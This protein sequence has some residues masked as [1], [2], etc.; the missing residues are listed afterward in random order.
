MNTMFAH[1]GEVNWVRP[2]TAL[3][4]PE[5][6]R[7][8]RLVWTGSGFVS[9]VERVQSCQRAV[10]ERRVVPDDR[11]TAEEL[12]CLYSSLGAEERDDLLQDILCLLYTSPSP[13]DR[14]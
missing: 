5:I 10:G 4:R 3:L 14:T 8:A 13:R 2:V 1:G 7:S 6:T 9:I 11:P 12:E